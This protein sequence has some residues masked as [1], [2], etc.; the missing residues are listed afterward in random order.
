MKVG[1]YCKT[2]G[3]KITREL[4][5]TCLERDRHFLAPT[6]KDKV[7]DIPNSV[8]PIWCHYYY[9]I[10]TTDFL[11]KKRGIFPTVFIRLKL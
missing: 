6:T 11:N 10:T 4:L 1:N 5:L 7:M 9:N 8:M 2:H 3:Y